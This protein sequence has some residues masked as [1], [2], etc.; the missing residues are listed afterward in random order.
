VAATIAVAHLNVNTITSVEKPK[1]IFLL[2]RLFF[3][4]SPLLFAGIPAAKA[5]CSYVVSTTGNDSN[6]GTV[7]APML[8]PQHAIDTAAPGSTICLRAGTYTP[9]AGI[10]IDRAL[11][12]T[13][14]PGEAVL[15][16]ADHSAASPVVSVIFVAGNDVTIQNLEISGGSFYGIHVNSFFLGFPPQNTHIS[17]VKVHDTGYTGIK[18]YQADGIVIENSEV[19]NTDLT[20]PGGNGI[21]II[22]SLPPATNPAG[23]GAI[24][25]G[26]YIHDSTSTGMYIKGGSVRALMENN[27]VA[28]V[29]GVGMLA[30]GDSDAQYIRNGATSECINCEIR[31]N[32]VAGTV[33]AGIGCWA[34][35]NA[36]IVNNTVINAAS[37]GQAS[38]FAVPNSL[39]YPCQGAT[40]A[41]N[42]F[43]GSSARPLVHIVNPGPGMVLDNNLYY[44]TTGTYQLWWE[45]PA[46][47]GYWGSLAAWQAGA[48]EDAHSIMYQAPLLDA[49]NAYRELAGSPSIDKGQT[50]A[51]VPVD[52]AGVVRP[53]GSAYDIGAF[54]FPA[55]TAPVPSL[56]SATAGSNQSANTGAMF[57]TALA[58]KVTDSSGNP[59]PA[60]PVTFTAPASGASATFGSASSA[61]VMTA[62]NGVATAPVLTANSI[63]GTYVVSAS[64]SNL[65]TVSFSLTNI[66]PPPPPVAKVATRTIL[67]GGYSA[68]GQ[69]F[70][71]QALVYPPSGGTVSSGTVQFF[72]NGAPA[73]TGKV[74]GDVATAVFKVPAGTPSAT[75]Y[76]LSARY[77][78]S[79]QFAASNSQLNTLTVQ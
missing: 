58:A 57:G 70:T 66:A 46:L 14:Y 11:T 67:F 40:V 79:T 74:N 29:G 7:G 23:N 16:S 49:N 38:F 33:Y 37:T 72:V 78:G 20:T 68:A 26:T 77:S 60:I 51:D 31:N 10:V 55:V 69:P 61:T 34:G 75:V 19:Y 54:E 25:R 39:G 8:T 32:V 56:L 48:G 12:L 44:S 41:N 17:H 22:A 45:A 24:V 4:L 50:L 28:R 15:L 5:Q 3:A 73:G 6:A 59:V 30:G 35:Q 21:D 65:N 62:S 13:A 27:L 63:G 9:A 43:Q 53:Q 42:I 36:R 2:K 71:M 47:T 64:A 18:A 76:F 1:G 52:Y